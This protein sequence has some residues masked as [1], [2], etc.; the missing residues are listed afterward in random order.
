MSKL[1]LENYR[2]D[3]YY[4][5][6]QKSYTEYDATF[7]V[8]AERNWIPVSIKCDGII[9]KLSDKIYLI[10]LQSFSEYFT[11]NIHPDM[12]RM[13]IWALKIYGIHR[14]LSTNRSESFNALLKRRFVK[15][16]GYTEDEILLGGYSV[17]TSQLLRINRARSG[18]GESW[19]LREELREQYS[20]FNFKTA[21]QLSE[22]SV[23]PLLLTKLVF[24]NTQ[25]I[26]SYL[27]LFCIGK[28]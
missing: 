4:L 11:A 12:E 7:K 10:S 9:S 3:F 1:D 23:E 27:N 19:L 21:S 15:K 20:L 17:L 24:Y 22:I 13:G 25:T 6:N 26:P 14:L 5:L 8:L 18:I 28:K 2:K 16:R